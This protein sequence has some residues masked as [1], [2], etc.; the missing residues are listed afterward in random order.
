MFQFVYE[1]ME[2]SHFKHSLDVPSSY[3][4]CPSLAFS[5]FLV[6]RVFDFRSFSDR[7]ESSTQQFQSPVSE[8]SLPCGF[9]LTS[10]CPGAFPT[11]SIPSP[12]AVLTLAVLGVSAALGSFSFLFV[13]IMCRFVA[14]V[15]PGR[16]PLLSRWLWSSI[17]VSDGPLAKYEAFSPLA[18]QAVDLHFDGSFALPADGLVYW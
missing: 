12:G 11:W 18:F 3:M 17:N 14:K 15:L 16:L 7:E 6:F 13:F 8:S 2:F 10:S 4:S 1:K 5:V 9:K